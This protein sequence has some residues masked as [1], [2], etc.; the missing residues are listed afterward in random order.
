MEINA[1][2][3][4]PKIKKGLEDLGGVSMTAVE[5]GEQSSRSPP[6]ARTAYDR[7]SLTQLDARSSM[8]KPI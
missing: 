6:S 5:F 2:F 8:E 7:K 1:G 4:D 3:A